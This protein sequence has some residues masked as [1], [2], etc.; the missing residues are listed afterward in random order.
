[1]SEKN[2]TNKSWGKKRIG[3][4]F[5]AGLV[6]ILTLVL[7]LS[8]LGSTGEDPAEQPDQTAQTTIPEDTAAET[9]GREVIT[10]KLCIPIG[11]GI[12]I[13]DIGGYTGIYME[14]GTDELVSEVLMLKVANNGQEAVEYA[15]ISLKIGDKT[16]EFAAT[17]LMPG[18]ALVLLE[19]NRMPY[20]RAVDYAGAEVVCENL[21]L[22]QYTPGLQEDKLS[23]QILDGAI[24]VTNISGEDITG[25]ILVYYK[26]YISGI[27][28][29]FEKRGIK[30]VVDANLYEW[31][32]QHGKPQIGLCL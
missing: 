21:A 8:G 26:N 14:D 11:N 31:Q 12:E 10:G 17:T 7:A 27:Y 9:A 15:K 1:M 4:L 29:N 19:Q 20:D 3:M 13:V 23:I 24:N 25:D 5:A 2:V 18:T 28:N 32:R 16:A 22:Y 6:V 30:T